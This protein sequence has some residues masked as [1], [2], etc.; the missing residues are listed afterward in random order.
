MTRIARYALLAAALALSA[1][2]AGA[3]ERAALS[4][5]ELD[6]M[7]APVALYP[8]PLL[9]QLLMA[10]TYPAEVVEAARWSKGRPGL[11]G[12]AAVKAA[13]GQGWDP[14]VTSLVAFPQILVW[15]DENLPW[16]RAVGDAFLAQ[17]PQVLDTVQT[18]RAR[19]QNAGNLR[20]DDRVLVEQDGPAIVVVPADPDVVY[21]PYYDPLVVY[22]TWWWPARP[23]V[24]WRPGPGYRAPTGN[25]VHWAPGIRVGSS[26]FFGALDWPRRQARVVRVNRAP[27]AWQ[28][29]PGHRRGAAYRDPSP[30][31]RDAAPP[32]VQE[33]RRGEIRQE[34]RSEE[35]RSE[36][37]R[38]AQRKSRPSEEKRE[39]RENR[40]GTP[41]RRAPGGFSPG[42]G[43]FSPGPGGFSPGPGGLGPLQR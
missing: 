25:A 3:Q 21:V 43:G 23:P 37:R 14:S 36:E 15:M 28:H 12:D 39:T 2:W 9:S 32:P 40:E 30:Q 4:Q 5:A 42:P 11:Q 19:A 33:E 31:R 34:R 1:T 29:D 8:D 38:G 13:A 41:Q 22:G 18:L 10:A 6:Q 35:R 20:S 24:R 16:T 17:Q 7:L 27:G 26:F